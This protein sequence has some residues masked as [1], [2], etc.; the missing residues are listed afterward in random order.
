MAKDKE[1]QTQIT[2]YHDEFR[3]VQSL[4]A[5]KF[6]PR[7]RLSKAKGLLLYFLGIGGGD[8]VTRTPVGND[9]IGSIGGF[10]VWGRTT[11]IVI[12]PGPGAIREMFRLGI[13]PLDIDGIVISHRHLDHYMDWEYLLVRMVRKGSL[14]VEKQA[15]P[16]RGTL[17][18][19]RV[20]MEGFEGDSSGTNATPAVAT[21][22]YLQ[23]LS[24]WGIME[25]GGSSH[26]IGEAK[27]YP[28][29]SFHHECKGVSVIPA[30]D[31]ALDGRYIVYLT[32]G[33][34]RPEIVDERLASST[35]QSPPDVVVANIQCLDY[36][37]GQ[38]SKGHLGWLGTIEAIRRLAP[39]I[40]VVR[41]WGLEALVRQEGDHLVPAPEKL[42]VYQ[43]ALEQKTGVPI[44]IPGST[45]IYVE[46]STITV[47]HCK[48]PLGAAVGGRRRVI[49]RQEVRGENGGGVADEI[50]PAME[51]A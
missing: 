49:T 50:A 41:S 15:A 10:G 38:Y 42:R 28:R 34:Y 44:V 9:L 48:P 43:D 18:A 31:V 16:P 29:H 8:F 22:F 1:W 2:S 19:S 12:D 47:E 24:A 40:A 30:P 32:D 4:A 25:A 45:L 21:D 23:R 3:E 6:P 36:I 39:R 20:F 46:D 5:F 17:L 11:H 27:I 14:A 7:D 26:Q 13:D 33:E 37:E 35:F 51:S